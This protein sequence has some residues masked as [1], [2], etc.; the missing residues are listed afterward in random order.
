[1]KALIFNG[2]LLG[3]NELDQLQSIIT[4]ELRGLGWEAEV[5]PLSVM[6]IKPCIGCFSA[7]A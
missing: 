4:E 5:V 6:N 7:R 3:H 2:S 1:M